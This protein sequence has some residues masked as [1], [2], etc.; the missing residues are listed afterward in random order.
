MLGDVDTAQKCAIKLRN[1]STKRLQVLLVELFACLLHALVQNEHE[2]YDIRHGQLIEQA[3][4]FFFV[5]LF[6]FDKTAKLFIA[7]TVMCE[8]RTEQHYL[9]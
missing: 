1:F 2:E 5:V 8:M 4:L 3:I 7:K 9:P 6:K